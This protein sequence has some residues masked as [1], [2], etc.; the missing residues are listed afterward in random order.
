MDYPELPVVQKWRSQGNESPRLLRGGGDRGGGVGR[1]RDGFLNPTLAETKVSGHVLD[2]EGFSLAVTE[3]PSQIFRL[4]GV[5]D[6]LWRLRSWSCRVLGQ[7]P[8]LSVEVDL[9]EVKRP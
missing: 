9:E 6:R 2:F 5:S 7:G 3:N 1:S 4:P 8:L